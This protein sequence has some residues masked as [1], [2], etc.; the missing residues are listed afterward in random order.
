M[1]ITIKILNEILKFKITI[2]IKITMKNNC[3]IK[4][5]NNK[6]ERKIK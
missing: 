4:E 2:K 6:N 3:K 5:I 1:I